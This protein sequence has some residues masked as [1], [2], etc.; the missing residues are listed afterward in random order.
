M[1]TFLRLVSLLVMGVFGPS[2]FAWAADK[3]AKGFPDS[4]PAVQRCLVLDQQGDW[5]LRR[6]DLA[7]PLGVFP[8]D[9]RVVVSLTGGWLVLGPDLGFRAQ[10]LAWVPSQA[11]KQ[12]EPDMETGT[13]VGAVAGQGVIFQEG[14]KMGIFYPKDGT[15][16]WHS[17]ASP[18]FDLMTVTSRGMEATKSRRLFVM[19]NWN[20]TWAEAEPLPF[21]PSDLTESLAGRPWACD[22]LQARPWILD[23]EF[24][25]RLSVPK[26]PGRMTGITPFP[27]ESGYFACG[28]SWVGAF[29]LDG[30]EL[31]ARTTSLTGQLLPPDLKIRAGAGRLYLWSALERRVWVWS[32]NANDASGEVPPQ[33]L[34]EAVFAAQKQAKELADRGGLPE[35]VAL[36][37][38]AQAVM[39]AQLALEPFSTVWSRLNDDAR[40]EAEVFRQEMVGE[41]TFSLTWSRPNGQPLAD[42]VWQPDA[43][44]APSPSWM[45]ASTPFWEGTAYETH[46][47]RAAAKA[48]KTPWPGV[49]RENLGRLQLPSWMNVV[50]FRPTSDKP[51]GWARILLPI[52]PQPY[53]LPT[54]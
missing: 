6:G 27:D 40:T 12:T 50:L 15:V 46:K 4:P 18:S 47:F 19:S 29:T 34:A 5:T 20:K 45:V 8:M 23:G 38:G 53:D 31:W 51:V 48:E 7:A 43:T 42:W 25:N 41:G 54:E 13:P 3:P 21:F 32:W 11:L 2:F 9:D 36:L 33:D 26:A 10:S 44:T 49:E 24:W 52:P 22:S 28:P 35:A 39:Q 17:A 14:S 16:F 37:A 1:K 30:K